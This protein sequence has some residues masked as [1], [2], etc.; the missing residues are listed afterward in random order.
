MRFEVLG[1]LTLTISM[2]FL[3]SEIANLPAT[4]IATRMH[5]KLARCS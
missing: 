2:V 4:R 3:L 5:M 1:A